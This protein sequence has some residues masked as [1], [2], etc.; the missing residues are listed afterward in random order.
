MVK[1]GNSRKKGE[2]VP[3]V[4]FDGGSSAAERHE[5]E[6]NGALMLMLQVSYVHQLE[7]PGRG[8]DVSAPGLAQAAR[9]EAERRDGDR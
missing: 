7:R 3:L 5:Q 9:D 1:N 8:C 6:L 4:A 2:N